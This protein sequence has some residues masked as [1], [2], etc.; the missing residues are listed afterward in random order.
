MARACPADM[1]MSKL[2][3]TSLLLAG[4]MATAPVVAE[5]A[6]RER[7]SGVPASLFEARI[8]EQVGR[9]AFE[10]EMLKPFLQLWHASRRPQLPVP[11]ESVTVYV[12]PGHPYLVGY[13][14][15]GCMI[16]FL[17]VERQQLWHWLRPQIGWPA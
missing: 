13:Q 2:L 12:V 6:K 5:P 14:F 15:Q 9:Y 1:A 11:P 17:A 3:V 4:L 7:C 10:G 16:A 8:G